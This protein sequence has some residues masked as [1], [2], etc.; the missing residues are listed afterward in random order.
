[1]R[2][3]S[4]VCKLAIVLIG[5]LG[6]GSP[7]RVGLEDVYKSGWGPYEVERVNPLILPY[8]EQNKD[9][10][11]RVSYPAAEGR[12]PVIVFSH[13]AFCSKDDY[14]LIA[15]HWASHGYVV[16]QPTHLDSK[17]LG[18]PDFSKMT[19]I[20]L[21]RLDDLSFIA[22]SLEKVEEIVPDLAGRLDKDRMAIAGHS[23]GAMTAAT[24]A[25]LKRTDN[26]GT[27]LAGADDRFDV[28]VLLSG[29]G[30]IPGMPED[31]FADLTQPIY[32]ASG[33]NDQV[34]M[35]GPNATWEWRITAF[36]DTPPG[37]KYALIM[38]DMTHPLGGLI[39]GAVEPGQRLEPEALILVNGTST[40][41]LD[42]Y[43]KQDASARAFLADDNV[44]EASGGMAEL[45]SR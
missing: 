17:T 39:C 37:D 12:Y 24:V 40:A 11:V 1:M 8:P 28:T 14:S 21:S 38:Q 41:F 43:L 7:A 5:S 29:P 23:M 13:G 36:T 16:F 9:L 19:A 45:R 10:R 15:D 25:G 18:R 33:P 4:T 27:V 2:R 26:D 42:A 31:A 6:M 32:V 3:L 44:K 34:N 22:D 35:A 30:P 20:F